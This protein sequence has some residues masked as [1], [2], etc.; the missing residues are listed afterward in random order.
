MQTLYGPLFL[1]LVSSF[2]SNFTATAAGCPLCR[3][4]GQVG[5][6]RLADCLV[7]HVALALHDAGDVLVVEQ[8]LARARAF[9]EDEV[10]LFPAELVGGRQRECPDVPAWLQTL[11][12]ADVPCAGTGPKQRNAHFGSI[13]VQSGTR[14]S[15]LPRQSAKK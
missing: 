10:A 4:L 2:A 15:Q 7:R 9:H 3:L 11:A 12:C 8:G 6:H 14:W 5:F 13:S 1:S